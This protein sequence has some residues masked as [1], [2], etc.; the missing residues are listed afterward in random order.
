MSSNENRF[1][2]FLIKRDGEP[3]KC[4]NL[5][6]MGVARFM[7]KLNMRF[8]ENDW[9]ITTRFHACGAD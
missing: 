6:K 9:S 8:P 5:P 3:V 1:E 4:M 7:E 2:E